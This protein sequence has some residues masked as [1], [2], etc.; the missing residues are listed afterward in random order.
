MKKKLLLDSIIYTVANILAKAIGFIMIPVYTAFLS[1][2][3]YGVVDLLVVTGSIISVVIG[4]EIHQ[5]VSRFFP[6][7]S[8]NDK[9][10][11]VS[12]AFWSIVFLYVFFIICTTPLYSKISFFLFDNTEYKDIV[13][14]AFLSFGFNFIYYYCSS[15]LKWQLKSKQNLLVSFIYS[16]IVAIITY[17]MLLYGYGIMSVFI[18]QIIASIVCAILS[19]MY[20]KEYYAFIFNLSCLKKM[21]SFSLPLVFSVIMAYAMVYADRFII[22][23]FLSVED[24]GIY[25][26]AF[27]FASVITLLTSGIQTALTPLIYTHYR[28]KNTPASIAKIFNYFIILSIL[29]ICFLFC[30]SEHIVRLV[31]NEF[32]IKA[33]TIIPWLSISVLFIGIINFAPGIF[34]AK[35]TS[36]V[37][38]INICSLVLNILLNLALIKKYE[39]MG[40]AYA[41]AISSFIY[42]MLYCVIGQK[43][44]YI[45][46]FWTRN[47]FKLRR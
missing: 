7:S 21:I 14:I 1:T 38:Y 22:K 43:Y 6:E 11:I 36:Y 9:I 42:F 28:D 16:L 29:L 17:F 30:F 37:L 23:Y 4:L 13:F 40:S 20:S 35:K 24:V 31:A 27:R 10:T 5:A 34:I 47:N 26:I 15:Q 32:Y 39:L 18:A 12:T 45:P 3:E 46:Y 33:A 41:T 8:N 2:K 25:G 44:Y 19:Y